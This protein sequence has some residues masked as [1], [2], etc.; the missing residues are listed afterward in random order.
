MD[1]NNDIFYNIGDLFSMSKEKIDVIDI[2]LSPDETHI[3]FR[4]KIDGFLW[5]MRIGE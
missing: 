5:M 3:I 1:I 2:S 4:N